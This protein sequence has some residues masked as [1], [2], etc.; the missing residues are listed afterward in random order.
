MDYLYYIL[1]WFQKGYLVGLAATVGDF[2]AFVDSIHGH[3]G[4]LFRADLRYHTACP[5]RCGN[6]KSKEKEKSERVLAKLERMVSRQ[7]SSDEVA[8]GVGTRLFAHIPELV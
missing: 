4:H 2:L 5:G 3:S 7:T 1:P 6:L 8:K